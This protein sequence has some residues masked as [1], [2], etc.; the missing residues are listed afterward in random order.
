[1]FVCI[2]YFR[3]YYKTVQITYLFISWFLYKSDICYLAYV[4]MKRIQP[5]KKNKKKTRK[6]NSLHAQAV[7]FSPLPQKDD[8][9]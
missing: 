2:Y 1:M 6:W 3:I 7:Q 9:H 5:W 8:E 4:M